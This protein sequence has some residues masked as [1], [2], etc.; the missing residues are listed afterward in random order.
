[1]S[2]KEKNKDV[3]KIREAELNRKIYMKKIYIRF[4]KENKD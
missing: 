4:K 3:L 2:K 1:M